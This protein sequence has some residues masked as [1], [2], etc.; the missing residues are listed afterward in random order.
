LRDPDTAVADGSQYSA[1]G[2]DY[3]RRRRIR[4]FYR[5]RI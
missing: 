5:D 3:C 2:S 1:R 4:S